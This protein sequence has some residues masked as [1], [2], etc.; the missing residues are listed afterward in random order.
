M[1]NMTQIPIGTKLKVI[2]SNKIVILK[3][4]RNYPTR[5]KTKDESGKIAYYRTHEVE[6]LEPNDET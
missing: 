4:I 1:E 6:I 5:Y 3:E 2:N